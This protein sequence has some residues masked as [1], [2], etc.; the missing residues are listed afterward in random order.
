MRSEREKYFLA[1][2]IALFILCPVTVRSQAVLQPRHAFDQGG[3]RGSGAT[4]A[5][6]QS[7]GQPVAG[8]GSGASIILDGGFLAPGVGSSGALVTA[9]L[10]VRAGWNMI[11]VPLEV[12]DFQ[13]TALFPTALS[14]AFMFTTQYVHQETLKSGVGY[15]IKFRGAELFP[16]AGIP[17]PVDTVD[18][19][20]GWNLI[21]TPTGPLAPAS[22]VSVPGGMV[23]SNFFAFESSYTAADSLRP[24][25]AYWVKVSGDG[26][27]ILPSSG[28]PAPASAGRV[29]IVPDEERP[30]DPPREAEPAVPVDLPAGYSLD[31]NYPNPF[32]PRTIIRYGLPEKVHVS[33]RLFNIL[34]EEVAAVVDAEQNAGAYSVRLNAAGLPGG[35][36]FYRISAGSFT[37]FKK[38]MLLK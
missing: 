8:K 10:E 14:N 34:G 3:G 2:L 26:V 21:G 13:R 9:L 20:Q 27:L 30:P 25:K 19:F 17:R 32:N 37:A 28:A 23:V 35:V 31:Q 38:M 1:G 12:A 16:M 22:V 6:L 4:L 15:W 5:V 11:S 33:L 7:I 36:Y 24:G 18:V 29:R